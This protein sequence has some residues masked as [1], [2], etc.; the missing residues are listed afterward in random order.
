MPFLHVKGIFTDSGN[1]I[2]YNSGVK[3]LLLQHNNHYVAF[4]LYT[5]FISA[6]FYRK[7]GKS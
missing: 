2:D 4:T 3:K 7:N 6:V 1:I 5:R